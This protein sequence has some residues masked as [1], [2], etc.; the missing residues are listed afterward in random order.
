MTHITTIEIDEIETEVI[1]DFSVVFGDIEIN[2]ITDVV[3]GDAIDAEINNDTYR[4]L[5]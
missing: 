5:F 1:I 4:E 3:T 2:Q